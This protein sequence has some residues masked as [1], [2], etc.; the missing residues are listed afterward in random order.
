M[1]VQGVHESMYRC[2]LCISLEK[3]KPL[4]QCAVQD[5]KVT[6]WNWATSINNIHY[7]PVLPKKIEKNQCHPLFSSF[8]GIF[9]YST[10]MWLKDLTETKFEFRHIGHH[11]L[12]CPKATII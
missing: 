2:L 9:K 5:G 10:I 8:K 7:V 11:N 12:L 1:L 6:L 4:A 3:N